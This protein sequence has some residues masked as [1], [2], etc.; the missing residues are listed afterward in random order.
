MV[1][2]R[3][4]KGLRPRKDL[5]ENIASPP[6]DVLDSDEAREIVKDNPHSFLRVVKPEVDL[7]PDIDLYSDDVYQQGASNLRRLIDTGEMRQDPEPMYYFYRQVM[8]GHSQVGLVAAVSAA[9]YENG[10]IKKHEFTR[11][12]KEVDRV[13]HIM[14]QRAQ[15]GPVFLTYPDIPEL[16]GLQERICENEPEADFIADDG[17]R[18][19][20]WTVADVSVMENIRGIFSDVGQLYVADGHHRSAAGT[21]VAR[22]MRDANPEHTGEEAY[23][24]FLAVIFP[25]SHMKIL[26]Y[27]R[28]VVDLNGRTSGEFLTSLDGDFNV[29]DNACPAPDSVHHYSM[30]LDGKWY[31]LVPKPDSFPENDPVKSLDSSIL[32]D[33]LL[34]P[35]LGIDDP[36]TS[37][38]IRF[39]GGI[40]GTGELE[41][42]VDSCKFVV[43]FSLYPVS[44]DQLFAVA[45]SGSVMPPKCTWFEPKLRSG[46]VVH[47]LD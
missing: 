26:A 31:G 14:S 42:L 20:L 45:D 37:Q 41:R 11:P 15:C 29:S 30:Y 47:L 4:F 34:A 22:R 18:H 44:L 21:I 27:N 35:I 8:D 10:L 3:P 40:R 1:V 16:N 23:N 43:A 7:D 24:F 38:R 33:N 17:I 6:Y 36:R 12:E 46:L 19:T 25:K 39:I 9:D 28:A 5:T 32:Q 13:R 2:V